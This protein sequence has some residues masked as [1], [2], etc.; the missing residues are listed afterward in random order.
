MLFSLIKVDGH[1]MEPGIRNGSFVLATSIY[2]LFF[3]PKIK[4]IVVFKNNSKLIIKRITKI[5]KEKYFLEGDNK[6][7]SKDFAP[8]EKKEILGKVLF[9]N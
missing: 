6:N 5:E 1:S 3:G 9:K 2:Y 7:D 8:I 4:D